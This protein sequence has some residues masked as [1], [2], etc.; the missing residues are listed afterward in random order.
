VAA[1]GLDAAGCGP[2]SD[3][4]AELIADKGY[5]SRA[6]L[7]DLDGGPWQTR[8]A[9][10]KPKE[11]Q[12]WHGDRDARRAVYGNRARLRSGVGKEALALRAE[13]V[14]RSFALTLDRGALRRTHLRGRENVQKRYFVHVAAYNL[15]LVMRQLIGAGT[16]KELAARGAWL[17]WL[18]DPDI[19]LLVVLIPPP[20]AAPEPTSSTGC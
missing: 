5:H 14:E 2:T 19:G 12:R 15:G 13:K 9:E 8:I 20:A 11:V 10:P 18:I 3:C 16:P 4:P 1:R 7:K 6:V 17:L